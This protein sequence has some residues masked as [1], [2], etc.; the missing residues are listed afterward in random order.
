MLE[1]ARERIFKQLDLEKFIQSRRMLN[2][3][4]LSLLNSSQKAFIDKFSKLVFRESSDMDTS[5]S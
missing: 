4:F 1:K 3:A 2:V 5:S